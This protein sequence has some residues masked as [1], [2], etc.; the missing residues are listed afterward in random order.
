MQA[1]HKTVFFIAIITFV[2]TMLLVAYLVYRAKKTLAYPPVVADC[3]DY[4]EEHMDGNNSVCVNVQNLG[5]PSCESKMNFT[6]SQWIG[7]SGLINKSNWAK[8]CDLTWD[9]V[10]NNTK[11]RKN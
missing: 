7:K 6:T 9:G 3:P 1:F 8:K 11:L 4:W 10:T 2:I 5:K